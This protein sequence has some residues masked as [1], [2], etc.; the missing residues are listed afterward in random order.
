MKEGQPNSLEEDIAKI[1]HA[2]KLLDAAQ[3]KKLLAELQLWKHVQNEWTNK[4]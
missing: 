4:N 3:K 1:I 2:L